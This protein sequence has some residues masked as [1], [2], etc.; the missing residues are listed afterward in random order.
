MNETTL[1][2]RGRRGVQAVDER[3]STLL[4]SA[5]TRREGATPGS[6][7]SL[8]QLSLDRPEGAGKVHDRFPPARYRSGLNRLLSCEVVPFTAR[9]AIIS[10]TTLQNLKPCP[11]NP[12]AKF[13]CGWSG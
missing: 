3:N 11:E 9:S 1:A 13:T 12:A 4:Q 8:G 2:I 6:L 5:F 10:P 7:V